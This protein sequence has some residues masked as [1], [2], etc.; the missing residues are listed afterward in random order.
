MSA[1]LSQILPSMTINLSSSEHFQ[2]KNNQSALLTEPTPVPGLTLSS[3]IASAQNTYLFTT[4]LPIIQEHLLK[5]HVLSLISEYNSLSKSFSRI[6]QID[7]NIAYLITFYHFLKTQYTNE[8]YIKNV[9]FI[10]L[11]AISIAKIH[12]AYSKDMF[13][14]ISAALRFLNAALTSILNSKSLQYYKNLSMFCATI[15]T[16]FKNKII[17]N[18]AILA[19]LLFPRK[20]DFSMFRLSATPNLTILNA[21]FRSY[22]ELFATYSQNHFI[23]N[24]FL[25][26]IFT[27]YAIGLKIT[28]DADITESGSNDTLIYLNSLYSSKI[29]AQAQLGFSID[30]NVNID[31]SL[32]SAINKSL[33]LFSDLTNAISDKLQETVADYQRKI[34][35][36]LTTIYNL[37]RFSIKKI[38]LQDL[39][40]NVCGVLGSA[41]VASSIV[42]QLISS[43]RSNFLIPQ[44]QAGEESCLLVL[45]ALSLATFCLF[46]KQLPG[47]NTI[48]EFVTRLD[49]FPK[50]I[51]GLESMWTRLDTVVKQLYLFI[52][53]KV[54]HR[55]RKFLS[56][57]MLKEVTDWATDVEHYLKMANRHEIKKDAK[58]VHAVARLYPRGI[59]LIKE[60]T[61]LKLAPA[62]LNLIRS[63][64]PAT[65]QLADEAIKSG[66]LKQS[67]RP[68]P[69]IVWFCGKSGLGKTGMSYPFMIDMMRVFGDVPADFQKNIYGRVPETEYWD[70]YIDQEYI[71]YDDAFQIKDNVLKPNPELFEIIRLGNAFPVML[72]MAS[73][74]EKNNTFANPK[75]VLLTSNI[76][77]IKTESLNSPEAV[78]RR[79]DFA[80]HVD[81]LPKYREYYTNSNGQECYKLN[82]ALARADARKL[83][84]ISSC[85][86]LEVYSFEQF[87]PFD[88][89]VV[90]KD[91]S[92]AEI[93]ADCSQKLA[94]RFDSHVDFS[95]YLDAYRNPEWESTEEEVVRDD[96]EQFTHDQSIVEF[97]IQAQAQSNLAT[98]IVTKVPPQLFK[99]LLLNHAIRYYI[100]GDSDTP[101]MALLRSVKRGMESIMDKCGLIQRPRSIWDSDALEYYSNYA[102]SVIEYLNNARSQMQQT[103]SN[104]F[105]RYWDIFKTAII[106][107]ISMFCGYLT[108]KAVSVSA[109]YIKSKIQTPKYV[110]ES[111]A[112]AIIVKEANSCLENDCKDCKFCANSVSTALNVVWNS[113]CA[114]YVRRMEQ[115]RENIR[116][117][118]ISL[119]GEQRVSPNSDLTKVDAIDIVSQ[120]INCDCSTCDCCN[121]EDL[122]SRLTSVARL[123]NTNCVCILTRFYQGFRTNDLLDMI[124][125]LK[126]HVPTVIRNKE[127]LRMIDNHA[128]MSSDSPSTRKQQH[129]RQVRIGAHGMM[130]SDSPRLNQKLRTTTIRS[131][132][133]LSS[134]APRV[135]SK[136][137]RTTIAA[138]ALMPAF[139][140]TEPQLECKESTE[141]VEEIMT[142][143]PVMQKGVACPGCDYCKTMAVS[144]DSQRSLPEQDRA[145]VT[146]AR[147][148]VYKNM[149]RFIIITNE[150]SGTVKRHEFGQIFM[151]GGRLGLIPKHFLAVIRM[152]TR[153]SA[154]GATLT[155]VLENCNN[156][157]TP[158]IP[159]EYLLD[160]E[161]F[162][163]H[164]DKDLA[165]VQLPTNCG[166]FA[167]AFNHIIDEQD[168][169]RVSDVPAILARYQ[170]ASVK[171][172]KTGVNYYRELFWLS[173][174]RPEDALVESSLSATE[175]VMNRGSYT[176]HAVTFFGDCGSILLASNAGVTKKIVG[177]HI[178]GITTMNKGISVAFTRQMIQK[179]MKHFNATSQYGHE[180]VPNKIEPSILKENGTFLIYGVEEGRRIMGSTSSSISPSPAHG[181][182][183]ES[184]NKPGYLKPFYDA[185][186][187]RIDPM[188]LQRSKYGVIR[189]FVPIDKVQTVYEAMRTF[190]HREY[191]NSPSYYKTPLTREE[192]IIGIDG[193][194]FINSINRQTAP[195]YPYTY[196]KDG[197]PGKTK[198]FGNGMD[199]DLT[200]QA[201]LDLS[202]DVDS[203]IESILNGVRPKVIW[204]DT[205]KD[206]KIPI[207]KA[208]VGKTRLFTAC[209]LHY[210]IAFRQYFLPFIAHCMRNRID[211]SISVGINPTSA[212]WT[213][214]AQRLLRNGKHVI[215]GDYS[216]FDG[217]LPVQYVETAVRIMADWFCTNFEDIENQKRNVICGK[218]LTKL[219]F[220]NFLMNLGTECVNH[221]HIANHEQSKDGALIYYVRNGIPSG[222]PATA[223]LN[224]I[225]NH[226][227]LAHSWLSIMDKTPFATMSAFFENTSSIFYGDD[228][229]MNIRPE[230]IDLFNQE[231][232]TPV[233]KKEL[234]M[235][236]TDEAKTGDIVKA[237]TLEEVSFLKRK[238][239]FEKMIQLWVSP[240]DIDVI[241]DAPNWVRLG[242]QLPLRICIDTLQGGIAELALHDIS[243]DKMYRERMIELGLKL[244]RNTG[245][246]F[247]P[248]SRSTTLMKFRNEQMGG[249]DEINY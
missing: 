77:V 229:I 122:K 14:P 32:E 62:N 134:D 31:N 4:P 17:N 167:Q 165:I 118:A 111:D 16:F 49:R 73:V 121:D 218:T 27:L 214:L 182:L 6:S 136:V 198:W 124:N 177:M 142:N 68:E 146:I 203:L 237:R 228:F 11:K 138:H 63:L 36:S 125:V 114:C 10:L 23:K 42:T 2:I 153:E 249:D 110:S 158:E 25:D 160:N 178:A 113:S 35:A 21:E 44:A 234:E 64:L 157:I 189:P 87:S 119:Y 105:G 164:P 28:T 148:V 161:N 210:T 84:G 135:G 24:A 106:A 1:H 20:N 103:I 173:G 152:K 99:F 147:D 15:R 59:Q 217:T 223:I 221:L 41:G 150:R 79:I 193:D 89:R 184:P 51:S 219:E 238:F 202:H 88:G 194:P 13:L 131:H 102:T 192:T 132:G 52:E 220:H 243:V 72:H 127:L 236:M 128:M 242:N 233:L 185:E 224:S 5:K 117:F 206:A 107:G 179:M 108:F 96:W 155:F 58:T 100:C 196:Q 82:A 151:L 137:I 212:E 169:F 130:S 205:L 241:L 12:F 26:T 197:M 33:T 230:V 227:V 60:C 176:Y 93:V 18:S 213:Q 159:C 92:Y 174:I 216:N 46:V 40:V 162:I 172:K 75:C 143:G 7:S 140:K 245:I 85:N 144:V 37:Y 47:K 208:N 116:T 67:L 126:E 225:V 139:A 98:R 22:A 78:Q 180:I 154:I 70:G 120:L 9:F 247:Y 215:A 201:Y 101:L 181:A 30:H 240:I 145:A 66:A 168:L 123:H 104:F 74:E 246:D 166:G 163:E 48:D 232:I 141:T 50:A 39:L 248:D 19:T 156:V 95:A 69:L 222:C 8:Q 55:E 149:F 71:I 207:K 109:E 56:T 239:R 81:I 29:T 235:T 199:Y 211:N 94:N 80:Y 3:G 170:E 61:Q 90:R 43:L 231:T 112:L 86:N 171:D 204:I 34:I 129:N 175:F 115:G 209:P 188:T 244:T 226:C 191:R 133:M 200:S 97:P 76:E 53:E 183:I 195:G 45:K 91:L 57:D 83:K 54:L 186:G 190:Y 38:D 65:K 187:N